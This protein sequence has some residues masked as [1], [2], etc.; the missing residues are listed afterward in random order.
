MSKKEIQDTKEVKEGKDPKEF[1][2][3][4]HES[5]EE[6]HKGHNKKSDIGEETLSDMLNQ[7]EKSTIVEKDPIDEKN[8]K[9]AELTDMLKRTQAEFINFKNRTEKEAKHL[10]EF[11]TSDLIKRM[12]P[13]LDSFEQALK[14]APDTEFKKGIEMVHIQMLD[15]FK[16]E[17][18]KSIEALG[19]K[20]DPYHHEVLLKEKSEKPED[21][22]IE[23]FQKGYMLKDKIIRYT[24]VKTSAGN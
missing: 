9:I 19:K 2:K 3:P 20:F 17:G 15:A 6:S 16:Q 13:V 10:C 12:L 21:I 23:E 22:V 14:N 5:K 4:K 18:L 7:L 8:Q 11:A 1:M 24:K